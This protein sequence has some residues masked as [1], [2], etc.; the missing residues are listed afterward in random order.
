MPTVT[1]S[2]QRRASA[3]SG[4][5][6]ADVQVLDTVTEPEVSSSAKRKAPTSTGSKTKRTKTT[7]LD[8]VTTPTSASDLP[9][10]EDKLIPA[11]LTFSFEEAKNHLI[12][13]D[14]RFEDVFD[15][16]KCTPFQVL[17]RVHPFRFDMHLQFIDRCDNLQ[18]RSLATSIM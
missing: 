3:A 15:R 7:Q 18:G 14:P 13:V 2:S 12:S 11:K 6:A 16:L 1:R 9:A 10:S 17:E 8:T 4:T 5:I